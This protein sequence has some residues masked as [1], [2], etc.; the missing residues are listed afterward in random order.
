MQ[1]A[2]ILL[3]QVVNDIMVV[4]IFCEHFQSTPYPE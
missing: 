1:T 4:I 2:P 3:D